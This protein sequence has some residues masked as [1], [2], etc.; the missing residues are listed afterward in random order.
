MFCE[1][2]EISHFARC[3]MK[4][5]YVCLANISH[6]RSKYFTAKRFHLPE[7]ANFVMA[8]LENCVFGHDHF[9]WLFFYNSLVF[10]CR[11]CYNCGDGQGKQVKLLYEPVAVRYIK[12]ES[13]LT[14]CRKFGKE[15]IGIA[16]RNSNDKVSGGKLRRPTAFAPSRNTRRQKTLQKQL[17]AP[18]RRKNNF[19]RRTKQ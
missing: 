10:F 19:I 14:E 3:E 6:L 12:K 2:C 15:V 13:G 8:V 9:G 4:F 1:H 18:V 11:L 17:R 16:I 7:W 5:A